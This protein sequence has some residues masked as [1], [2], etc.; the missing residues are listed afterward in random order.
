MC[1]LD[2]H[3]QSLVTQGQLG[4]RPGLHVLYVLLGP[5]S[6]H[7]SADN[8]EKH[9]DARS[10]AIDDAVLELRKIAPPGAARVGDCRHSRSKREAVRINAVVARVRPSFAGSREDMHMNVD[11]SG[12]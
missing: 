1:C 10:G 7:T 6:A 8:I 12:G 5:D 11:E 9:E 4:R 2:A 3:D